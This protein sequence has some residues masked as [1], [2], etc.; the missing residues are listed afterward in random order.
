MVNLKVYDI[1]GNEVAVLVN[2]RQNPGSYNV[3]FDASNLS[4]GIYICKLVSSNSVKSIK[5]S[6]I[7]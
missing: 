5:M 7:K 1:L 4:S 3:K 6:L 2:E